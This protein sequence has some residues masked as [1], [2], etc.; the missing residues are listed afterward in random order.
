V[1]LAICQTRLGRQDQAVEALRQALQ[2]NPNHQT[3]R[4]YLQKLAGPQARQ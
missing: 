2:I 3:A 1:N 4:D